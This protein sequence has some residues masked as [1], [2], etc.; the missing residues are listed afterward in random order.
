M[1]DPVL[2]WTADQILR[3]VEDALKPLVAGLGGTLDVAAD[4]D[5]ALELLNVSPAKWRVILGW[6]GF[7]SHPDAINGMGTHRCYLIVQIAKGMQVNP[8]HAL[9]RG[10]PSLPAG[11]MA[12]LIKEVTAWMCALWFP[13]GSHVDQRGFALDGSA[14]LEVD[15]IETKQH[16]IDFSVAA[17]LPSHES[18]IPLSITPTA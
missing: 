3:A 14:W 5:H 4:P 8:G 18:R 2:P 15:G 7:G 12:A 10:R 16:Q 6:P 11:P 9:H 17:A 13:D 1:S